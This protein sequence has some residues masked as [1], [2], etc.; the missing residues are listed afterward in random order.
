MVAFKYDHNSDQVCFY[1]LHLI[2]VNFPFIKLLAH[3]TKHIHLLHEIHSFITWNKSPHPWKE[4]KEK[5][6]TMCVAQ[7]MENVRTVQKYTTLLTEER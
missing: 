6:S 5:T 7:Y 3:P 2:A 4:N 1:W